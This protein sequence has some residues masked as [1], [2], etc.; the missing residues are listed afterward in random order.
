[1]F[2]LI[3]DRYQ[4]LF[5]RKAMSILRS[6]DLAEDAVQETF[7]R[8]Y[9]HAQSFAEQE[10][11]SFRSWAYRILNNTCLTVLE[12]RNQENQKMRRVEFAELDAL[13]AGETQHLSDQ[14]SLVQSVL[15]RL[16]EKFS[17]LLTLYFFEEKSYEE[18]AQV[19]DISL[20]AVRSGLHRAKKQFKAIAIDLI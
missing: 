6:Q 12:R 13:S 19:E 16:P 9:K 20:S 14:V 5:L 18:I 1:M 8:I 7:L 4:A 17:R 3:V 15:I 10:G 2:G 11:A